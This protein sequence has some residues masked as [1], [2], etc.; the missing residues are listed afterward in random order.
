VIVVLRDRVASGASLAQAMGEQPRVFDDLCVN[1]TEVV[2]MPGRS[3]YP[4]NDWPSLE[5]DRAVEGPGGHC[6]DLPGNCVGGWPSLPVFP[7]D[8]RCAKILEP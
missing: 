7:H 8:L 4:S 3:I 5:S 1:I 6:F 2:K